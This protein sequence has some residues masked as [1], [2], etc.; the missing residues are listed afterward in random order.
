[1]VASLQDNRSKLKHI[2]KIVGFFVMPEYRGMGIGRKLLLEVIAQAKQTKGVKKIQL[3]VI[4]TQQSAYN[5]YL[6]LGFKKVGEL[7]YAVKIGDDYFDKY[8]MELYLD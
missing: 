8:L 5:L 7:K 1:M 6:S 3:G 4:V 2:V